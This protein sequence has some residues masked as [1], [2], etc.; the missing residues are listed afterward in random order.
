MYFTVLGTV[1][2]V[3]NPSQNTNKKI[4][5]NLEFAK[6][7]WQTISILTENEVATRMNFDDLSNEFAE[8]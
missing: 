6:S 4:I 7:G 5:W 8:K 3:Q 1:V 2:S